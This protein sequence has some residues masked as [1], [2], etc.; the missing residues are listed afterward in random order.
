LMLQSGLLVCQSTCGLCK[1]SQNNPRMPRFFKDKHY[2]ESCPL[3]PMH[4][5]LVSKWT[6]YGTSYATS[7]CGT[8][9]K[10]TY[11]RTCDYEVIF[12]CKCNY[13]LQ[14]LLIWMKMIIKSALITSTASDI[15]QWMKN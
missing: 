4:L 15:Q 3:Q 2:K 10:M 11:S 12:S 13:N 7:L 5:R 6:I 8:M 1:M 14:L 9:V